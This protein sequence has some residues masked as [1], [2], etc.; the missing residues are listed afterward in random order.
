[1][2][3]CYLLM[4]SKNR[5]PTSL[6]VARLAGVSQSAVSRCFTAGASISEKTRNKVLKA[7][8]EL[9]YQPNLIA[10]SLVTSRSNLVAVILPHV[11]NRY[12]PEVL[13]CLSA[14]LEARSLRM[15][16]FTL[17]HD[18]EVNSIFE[19][20]MRHQVDGVIMAGRPKPELLEQHR[21]RGIPLILYNR[22][23]PELDIG[24]VCCDHRRSAAELARRLYR[25][26]RRRFAIVTGPAESP[27]NSE[28]EQGFRDELQRLGIG[29]IAAVNGAYDYAVSA[30]VVV[31]LIHRQP[32]IDAI[33]CTNDVMAFA[34]ADALRHRLGRTPGE[35]IAV[36]GFD[37]MGA[38]CWDSYQ[39]T[40]VQQPLERM[41]EA[42]VRLLVE[43]I[44]QPERGAEHLFM[45]GKIIVRASAPV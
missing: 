29:Q 1:M 12:Y 8:Q 42:A 31:E 34:T 5:R 26:G 38:A 2:Q 44:E 41:A 43:T 32:D 20:I 7:A 37:D 35:D 25:S 23:W 9:G 22:Y 45:P 19:E 14:A 28:R 15:L 30:R 18:E 27:T 10:R 13:L 11:T 21:H 6:Q 24:S 39:L 17:E 4:M 40:T 16:L 36:A 3:I 33:F